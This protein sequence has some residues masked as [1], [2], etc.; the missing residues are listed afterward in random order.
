M[1]ANPAL[2]TRP[3]GQMRI[4]SLDGARA[5]L[6]LWVVFGHLAGT[7]GA[8][9][10]LVDNPAVAVD[11]FMVLSGFFIA[12]TYTSLSAQHPP[13]TAMRYF[14]IRRVMRIWPVYA[15]LLTIVWIFLVPLHELRLE[16]L[17][18]FAP[19][20][21]PEGAPVVASDPVPVTLWSALLHYT[22]LFGL[23]PSQ[24][25]ATAL[26]DWSL[27]LEF[28]FYLV[29]PLLAIALR[30]RPLMLCFAAAVMAFVSPPLFGFYLTPGSL[31]HFRQP[32][33]LPYRLHFFLLGALAYAMFKRH[34]EAA[35][36]TWTGDVLA[37]VLCLVVMGVQATLGVFGILYLMA[38]PHSRA[39]SLLGRD[40]MRW[41]GRISFSIYLVHAPLMRVVVAL[42]VREPWFVSLPPLARFAVAA[43]CLVPV[44][45]V[46]AQLLYRLVEQPGIAL[47]HRWT[48]AHGDGAT[49][50]ARADA[51][52]N[53]RAEATTSHATPDAALAMR[54]KAI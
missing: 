41:L 37:I 48:S 49:P 2:D 26:P 42:L 38:R 6:A 39:A 20:A 18:A 44:V 17:Q 31:A 51:K 25:T 34:R 32:A 14:W 53:A 11:L 19:V 23:L 52:A 7:V 40:T 47:A 43:A 24:A 33:F 27:S 10:P 16:Q 12:A 45:L 46:A 1:S 8:R 13:A 21:L 3:G 28:Q 15:V 35:D 30:K 9:L 5:L 22:M 50:A 29:F 36:A 54:E 4:G